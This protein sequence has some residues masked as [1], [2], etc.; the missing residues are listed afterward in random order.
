MHAARFALLTSAIA[1]RAVTPEAETAQKYAE[2]LKRLL[3]WTISQHGA[4]LG[5]DPKGIGLIIRS[6][7]AQAKKQMKPKTEQWLNRVGATADEILPFS[8]D[9]TVFGREI[10][11]LLRYLREAQDTDG[12]LWLNGEDAHWWIQKTAESF[13]EYSHRAPQGDES[14]LLRLFL[15]HR[16]VVRA[17]L[18]GPALL[19]ALNDLLD[20]TPEHRE[21]AHQLL[22]QH[23]IMGPEDL[24]SDRPLCWSWRLTNF[25]LTRGKLVWQPTLAIWD[26]GPET[27][28]WAPLSP[29]GTP[30]KPALSP[31]DVATLLEDFLWMKLEK[32][33]HAAR[34]ACGLVVTN[35]QFA[36][37]EVHP[38]VFYFVAP[39]SPPS[40]PAEY[41]ESLQPFL[42]PFVSN[43]LRSDDLLAHEVAWGVLEGALVTLRREYQFKEAIQ[44]RYLLLPI[45][46]NDGEPASQ[47]MLDSVVSRLALLEFT[48]GDEAQDIVIDLEQVGTHQALWSGTL[49]V[50]SNQVN[51][52]LSLIGSVRPADRHKIGL[53][54]WKT[55]ILLH[56][57][58]ALMERAHS[59]ADLVMRNYR[60]YLDATEDFIRQNL[61]FSSPFP[62]FVLSL[63]SALLD[64][65]PY[66]YLQEPLK[67]LERQVCV[68][69]ENIANIV[70]SLD[71]ALSRVQQQA[72]SAQERALQRLGLILALLALVVGIPQLIPSA[73]IS[74]ANYPLWLRRFFSLH[75]L[76]TGTRILVL[77][78][79]ALLAAVLAD[80]FLLWIFS[81]FPRQD[82]FLAQV[83]QLWTLVE[84][85][86]MLAGH[87]QIPHHRELE[88]LDEQA[89]G[90][91]AELWEWLRR[92]EKPPSRLQRLL[93]HLRKCLPHVE[94]WLVQNRLL[95]YHLSLWDLRP[96]DIPLPRTLCVF[97]YKSTDF[98]SRS[99]I[100]DGEFSRSLRLVGFKPEEEGR[101]KKWLS[102]MENAQI[103]QQ[104]TVRSFVKA[105]KERG[106]TADPNIRNHK[107]WQ[108]VIG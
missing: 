70:T 87:M 69:S 102:E 63:R 107:K 56:R 48:I 37:I 100:S 21:R 96:E 54:L 86:K 62:T 79:L 61:S 60:R 104:M 105:L 27:Q 46:R 33:F 51:K 1:D 66:H 50:V 22:R 10:C 35:P 20:A 44:S 13:I 72:K 19:K 7:Y 25:S 23:G 29:P 39:V 30:V 93:R 45:A 88:E 14:L 53:E 16:C 75:A 101:L 9:N 42:R 81:Q 64:A 94:A 5:V 73:A 82:R 12:Y 28:C 77:I 98:H 76:E 103:I 71:T 80:V 34:Q 90:L 15:R 26:A 57:W 59:D 55:L 78:A 43:C 108:G 99:V 52:A 36:E 85:A 6:L 67:N 83:Q 8:P 38:P 4:Q 47:E 41:V 68:L 40:R 32:V 2:G 65:Y 18:D 3:A 92:T 49:Y 58:R 106:V 84:R 24:A 31:Q 97:R 17:P 95:R 74:E 11:R 89:C 91:A